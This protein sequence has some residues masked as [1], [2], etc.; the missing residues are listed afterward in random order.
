M[1]V[2]LNGG[3]TWRYVEYLSS[4]PYFHVS[5]RDWEGHEASETTLLIYTVA[6][7]VDLSLAKSQ[8][9]EVLAVQLVSPPHINKGRGWRMDALKS[10]E[11]V[12]L[13]GRLSYLYMLE[14]GELFSDRDDLKLLSSEYRRVVYLAQ[15]SETSELLL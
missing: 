2:P 15:D 8:G 11:E 7:L 12:K 10:V 13:E 14:T 9:W 1:G 6:D 3:Q 5:A 4:Y